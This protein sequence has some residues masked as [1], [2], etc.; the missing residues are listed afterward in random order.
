MSAISPAGAELDAGDVGARDVLFEPVDKGKSAPKDVL[1]E[2][3]DELD[4]KD[5]LLEP[6]D[7]VPL[8]EDSVSGKGG[9]EAAG[10]EELESGTEGAGELAS[11]AGLVV[12]APG[13]KPL[14]L[15]G[16]NPLSLEMSDEN[17]EVIVDMT[18]PLLGVS[19]DSAPAPRRPAS[20]PLRPLPEAVPAPPPG[21]SVEGGETS[22]DGGETSLDGGAASLDGVS[23]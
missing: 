21:L 6:A 7:D 4:P 14:R 16:S 8:G 2:P 18:L 12:A 15:L 13:R 20:I 1:F 3:A 19:P 5:V 23:G 10:D 9:A 22:L 17:I 11:G